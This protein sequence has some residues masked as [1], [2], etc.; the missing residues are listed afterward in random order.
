MKHLILTSL[1]TLLSAT[2]FAQNSLITETRNDE[3]EIL[4]ADSIGKTLYVF[5]IDQGSNTSKCNADCAEVW[6]PYLITT[7]EAAGLKAPL[8]AVERANKKLQLTYEGRPVYTYIFDRA[9]GDDHG[10]GLGG[11]WHYIE[12]E[13]K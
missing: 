11:V 3:Q 7:A 8:G 2:S 10:D 9:Q 1:L 4:V 13:E 5:D 6:P 12:L